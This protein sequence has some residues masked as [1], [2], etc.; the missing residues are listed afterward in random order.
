MTE[1]LAV[2]AALVALPIS[3]ESGGRYTPALPRLAFRH[4]SPDGSD[5]NRSEG[6]DDL[7]ELGQ[8]GAS[9]RTQHGW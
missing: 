2:L 4:T 8:E 6:A 5:G 3:P 7:H 1:V 9:R